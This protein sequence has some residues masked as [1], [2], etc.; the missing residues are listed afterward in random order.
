MPCNTTFNLFAAASSQIKYI[1]IVDQLV[2]YVAATSQTGI[3]QTHLSML[4]PRVV[5]KLFVRLKLHQQT[6]VFGFEC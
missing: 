3:S 4:N 1:H 5:R 2:D 6:L